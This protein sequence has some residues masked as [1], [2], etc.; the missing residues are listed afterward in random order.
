ML[1]NL[2]SSAAEG[3]AYLI[4]LFGLCFGAVVGV[5]MLHR[6]LREKD[7]K[8]D[9]TEACEEKPA[10]APKPT[11]TAAARPSPARTPAKKR[12]ARPRA[13]KIYYILERAEEDKAEKPREKAKTK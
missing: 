10:P 6:K 2:L 13:Q 9:D 1:L 7:E 8:P 12:T 3:A 11:R 5:K 4:V